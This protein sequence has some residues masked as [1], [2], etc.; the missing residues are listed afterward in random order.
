MHALEAVSACLLGSWRE[1]RRLP[2]WFWIGMGARSQ[3]PNGSGLPWELPYGPRIPQ[4]S[5]YFC[6]E[7]NGSVIKHE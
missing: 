2:G 6:G 7:K 1:R 3:H 5:M 4:L